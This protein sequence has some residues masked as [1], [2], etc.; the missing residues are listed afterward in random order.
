MLT[1]LAK[2]NFD[3]GNISEAEKYI[4]KSIKINPN[5]VDNKIFMLS[6]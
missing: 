1:G 4:S 5:L 6:Y 3:L 2:I